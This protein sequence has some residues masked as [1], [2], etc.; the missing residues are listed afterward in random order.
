MVLYA[1]VGFLVPLAWDVLYLTVARSPHLLSGPDGAAFARKAARRST[2]SIVVYPVAAGIAF[3]EP[4][5]A[6]VAFAALPMFF[7]G[8]VIFASERVPSS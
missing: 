5:A 1:A 2:V 7:I 6:L 8:T 4:V 3:I